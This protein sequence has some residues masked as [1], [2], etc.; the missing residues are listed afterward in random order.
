M[1]Y[2]LN[3]SSSERGTPYESSY[4]PQ[5]ERRGSH[6]PGLESG[7]R[8]PGHPGRDG[9]RL[10]DEGTGGRPGP[11]RPDGGP[12][13]GR[14]AGE[15]RPHPGSGAGSLSAG[16]RAGQLPPAGRRHPV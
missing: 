14:G 7:P 15:R 4:C 1:W 12:A 16:H 2:T 11:G 5:P 8:G 6:G 9:R 13:A 10:R 3:D